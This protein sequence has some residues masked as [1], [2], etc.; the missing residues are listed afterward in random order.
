MNTLKVIP[1]AIALF[2]APLTLAQEYH[3]DPAMV[4]GPEACA[5][6]HEKTTEIWKKTHHAKTFK[7]L[8]RREKSDEIAKNLGVKRIKTAAEC[9]GCHFTAELREQKPKAI[10]GISCESCHSAGRDWIDIH[11]DFGGKDI[12]A[13]DEAPEHR[14][15]RYKQSEA[16]GMIRPANMEGLIRNCYSCHMISDER[17][18]NVGGHSSSSAF[19]I[20]RWSQGEVRHN[21][22]Y[23]DD[24]E[25]SSVERR[26]V[27]FLLGQVLNYEYA[28][29]A[30]ATATENGDFAKAVAKQ[31]KLSQ[32]R[33]TRLQEMQAVDEIA[34]V[35][36][37]ANASKLGLN[38]ASQ[39]NQAADKVAALVAEMAKKYDGK[40]WSGIDAVLPKP[41]KYKGSISQ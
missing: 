18:V 16:A 28:L 9:S 8:P 24:N 30:L 32:R 14:V 7:E 37:I 13:E 31:A 38:K 41:E 2:L 25:E 39:L 22:W 19:E 20:V 1:L 3:L 17:L 33:L 27:M 11:S 12:E 26:R 40:S 34:A 36:K 6:C 35:L 15:Q 4:E 5:E 29:R 23:S 21:V 10:A